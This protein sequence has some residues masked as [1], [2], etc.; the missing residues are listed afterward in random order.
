MLDIEGMKDLLK[1][2]LRTTKWNV[3]S[4]HSQQ[5]KDPTH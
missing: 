4:S 3:K 1:R 5:L 2:S